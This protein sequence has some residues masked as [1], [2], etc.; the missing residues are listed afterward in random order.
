M[1]SLYVPQVVEVK[2]NL[3]PSE[4]GK[5]YEYN[6]KRKV[7]DNYGDTCYKNGF[8]KKSSIEIVSIKSGRR[9][10]SHLT[11]AMT[12]SVKFRALFC[13]PKKGT[14][15]RAVVRKVNKFGAQAYT[16]PMTITVP[17]Q[18]Q[19]YRDSYVFKDLNEGEYVNIEVMDYTIRLSKLIL[20]GV[21]VKLSLDKSNSQDLP[22]DLLLSNNY[23][24]EIKTSTEVPQPNQTMGDSQV[25]KSLKDRIT[26]HEQAWTR[27]ARYMINSYELIDNYRDTENASRRYNVSMI[28]YSNQ[29]EGLPEVSR[30]KVFPVFSRAYFKIWEVIDEMKLLE[31]GRAHV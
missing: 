12:F 5:D 11:G 18:L 7:K 13:I 21:I 1:D 16:W 8:I 22:K 31:I 28:D 14:I 15:I 26:P 6:I 4:I 29:S 17:R 23:V 19:Q 10:G 2:I 20:V 27:R 9:Y 25:L 30:K 3:E 24:K